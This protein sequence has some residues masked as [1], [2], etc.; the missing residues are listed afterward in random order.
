MSIQNRK[1]DHVEL[2]VGG[3]SAY[4]FDAGFD[5]FRLRHNALPELN[6]D[7]ISTS[8]SLLGRTFSLPIF[9]S[10]M[11]GGYSDAQQV[12]AIIARVCEEYDIPFGVGSQRAML[13][14]PSQM[15]S[16]E[17]VRKVA[18]KAFIAANI[19]GAQLI[20]HLRQSKVEILINTIEAN[21]IIV[22]LNPLQELMQPE[23]DRNFRGILEGIADIVSNSSVPVI[24]K[25][26]GAGITGSVAKKLAECGVKVIDI[27]GSGGTSW[28]K[29]EN[30][31]E[32][33]TDPMHEF[34]DW[35]LSTAYCLQDVIS[36]GLS[37]VE[38]IASGGIRSG[39]DVVKSL[40]LGAN[41]AAIAQ[42]AIAA[43]HQ[44]G[45]E[46]LTELIRNWLKV[47]QY[48]MI[49]L[50]TKTISQLT[51]QHIIEENPVNYRI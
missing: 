10:S 15:S 41:F 48:S 22:H 9:I 19:G 17:I 36:S 4:T 13:E 16:F 14:D 31:R 44:N 11:T 27:A 23:G 33:S 20:G 28:A 29:V 38:I 7:E 42:P 3:Q 26:T 8:A 6:I 12:N 2:T 34:N 35:G 18:P 40:C 1:K 49:L 24:V 47:V 21:A 50:G 30:L 46:G 51:K 43:I 5:R 37:D 39:F 25:E 32:Q 45:E